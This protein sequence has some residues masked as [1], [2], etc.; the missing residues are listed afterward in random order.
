[1][2]GD[3]MQISKTPIARTCDE[4]EVY[5]AVLELNGKRIL[6]LGCGAAVLTRAI[7]A[8]APDSHIDAMEVD[9][10][11]HEK[12]LQITDLPSV[13]FHLSGAQAIPALDD[14]YDI[15]LLFKSLHHV[16]G[17]LLD[18]ALHEIRRV[19]KPDGIAYISEPI[20]A[21]DF[22][23]LISLF[24]DEKV[25]RDNAFAA[26]Q[27]AVS[28]GTFLLQDQLF[29]NT[30]I[31]FND[32]ADFEN[33]VIKATH[34]EHR[35]DDAIYTLVQKRFAL[36]QHSNGAHFTAPMRVDLLVKPQSGVGPR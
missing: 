18:Q 33:K 26:V 14:S 23:A 10:I 12:N 20:Y 15:V 8:A 36:N 31:V 4:V 11:Q 7:A 19:L 5:S 13:S 32:F 22:N 16:H 3:R 1:M 34:T 28:K 2:M 21:G 27:R 29:F 25:A 30:P 24:H 9:V 35:L 6:E 17:D